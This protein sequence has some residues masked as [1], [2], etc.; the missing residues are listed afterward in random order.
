VYQY[1][2]TSF[3]LVL[4]NVRRSV[5]I[6][7]PPPF[8]MAAVTPTPV[9]APSGT[10]V[11]PPS[12]SVTHFTPAPSCSPEKLWLVSTQG[13]NVNGM[14][15][16]NGGFPSWAECALTLAGDPHPPYRNVDC[17]PW[18]LEADGTSVFISECPVGYTTVWEGLSIRHVND[19]R[20]RHDQYSGEIQGYCGAFRS[21]LS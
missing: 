17:Y 16:F 11:P 10:Y 20:R 12:H 15:Y 7:R 6:F 9:F 3:A 21:L 1:K 13:C 2:N 18:N 14:N 8:V 4:L 19:H 5:L